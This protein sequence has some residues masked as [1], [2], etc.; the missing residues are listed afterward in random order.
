M[1]HLVPVPAAV[2]AEAL[3]VKKTLDSF[4][5]QALNPRV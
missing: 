3:Q 4:G 1:H 5:N 2:A